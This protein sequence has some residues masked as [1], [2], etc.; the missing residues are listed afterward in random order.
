[1][2]FG[3]FQMLQNSTPPLMGGKVIGSVSHLGNLSLGLLSRAS[4]SLYQGREGTG[5]FRYLSP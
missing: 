5:P 3:R 1:M 2:G 4:G